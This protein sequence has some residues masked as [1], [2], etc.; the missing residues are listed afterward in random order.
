MMRP[1]RQP[2]EV[3][4]VGGNIGP[5]LRKRGLVVPHLVDLLDE[6]GCFWTHVD[7]EPGLRKAFDG[8]VDAAVF[9]MR[10]THVLS[11]MTFGSV[12]TVRAKKRRE[13]IFWAV[14]LRSTTPMHVAPV[15]D[16]LL[17]LVGYI[18]QTMCVPIVHPL[19]AG[20]WMS[21]L[22]SGNAPH[23]EWLLY[24]W[25]RKP[26]PLAGRK[27]NM[28]LDC[29]LRDLM[30]G[31]SC[32]ADTVIGWMHR[33]HNKGITEDQACN[34]FIYAFA[35]R[36]LLGFEAALYLATWAVVAPSSAKALSDL[37]KAMGQNMC[38]MGRIMCE[39]SVL[40]GRGVNPT[41]LYADAIRRVDGHLECPLVD[42]PADELRRC[43]RA[44]LERELR[45]RVV[46]PD[47]DE[48]FKRRYA[49][50]VAGAHNLR[51]NE[52]W[53]PQRR[54]PRLS[55][56]ENWN[57]R[58]ALNCV[59]V[60]PLVTW[61]GRVEVSVAEKIE[62]GKGRA[63][64]SCDT[65]S[66]CAF[67][68]LLESVER[69]WASRSVILNPGKDGSLGMLN[70]IRG[71]NK[72][73]ARRCYLMLDYSDFNSQHSNEAMRIVIEETLAVCSY[74]EDWLA[75]K[76]IDSVENMHIYV[77]GKY[78]GRVAGSLMSGH[79]ATTYW[80]S[81]LNAAYVRYAIG[82]ADYN[83]VTPFHVGDDVLILTEEP[84]SAWKM[85]RRIESVGC[86]LQ[87]SK[88]SVGM[89]GYEFLRVAGDPY[90]CVG[91]YVSRA[92]AG[93]VSGNWVTSV[94][95]APREALQSL[96]QQSRSIMNRSGNPT[97]YGL[98]LGSAERITGIGRK[99]LD[100][101]L[102]GEVA[103]APGPCYR[104]DMRYVA[105]HIEWIGEKDNPDSKNVRVGG[106]EVS[107]LP[108]HA[109]VD[110]VTHAMSHVERAGLGIV[111]RIPWKAMALT[112]YAAMEPK[113]IGGGGDGQRVRRISPRTVRVLR[114]YQTTEGVTTTEVKHGVLTQYPILSIL[115]NSFSCADLEYLLSL[116][117][118]PAGKDPRVT[119]W[120][121]GNEGVTICGTLPYSD[122][123]G[124][125]TRVLG[126]A[127]FV[128][129]PVAV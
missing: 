82:E 28:F 63:I 48:F 67:S 129:V 4:A 39:L 30:Q 89:G 71:A 106:V 117:G 40:Q 21:R 11:S 116:V 111:G 14:A 8:L 68:W 99:Y 18:V 90:V 122:A 108:N 97:A 81:V 92:I 124:M 109:A 114:G 1:S 33:Y 43:V 7:D 98:L 76:L 23:K 29:V 100:E 84:V 104:C 52:H 127:I 41:D 120:G 55:G 107:R 61:D 54:L 110:Y 112:A 94:K 44:V 128:N 126:N 80:N 56:V 5:Q 95:M 113:L 10:Q 6:I 9:D 27:A 70:R 58:A 25:P 22:R 66:Y 65:L 26:H 45:G 51:T 42:I 91:G 121:G 47:C 49:W 50:C 125:A 59:D 79:R 37:L 88:Q 24:H 20:R 16:M 32:F 77:G 64:Y 102:S 62:H 118:V 83:T 123:A 17:R 103:V 31:H 2:C 36:H 115:R 57:R 119:A 105:R 87:P 60:N 35:C 34:V 19:R 13:E 93:L 3:A 72:H 12:D 74:R 96:I 101:F 73:A 86:T 75:K 15:P 78:L 46:L 38:Y 69:A 53:L 85:I